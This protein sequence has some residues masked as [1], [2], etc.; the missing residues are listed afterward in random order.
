[1][2][3]GCG[4]KSGP[5][6]GL[7]FA[8]LPSVVTNQGK[9]VQELSKERRLRWISAIGCDDLTEEILETNRV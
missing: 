7:Y 2:I 1:M 6:K 3:V 8:R 4:S 5:Y 9:V